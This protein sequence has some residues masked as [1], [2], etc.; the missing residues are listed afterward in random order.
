MRSQKGIREGGLSRISNEGEMGFIGHRFAGW[1]PPRTALYEECCLPRSSPL[2]P[3]ASSPRLSLCIS[4]PRHTV[5]SLSAVSSLIL[6]PQPLPHTRTT[7]LGCSRAW[8]L[9]S[10]LPVWFHSAVAQ[11]PPQPGCPSV[12]WEPSSRAS[13]ALAWSLQ[14]PLTGLWRFLRSLAFL[15]PPAKGHRASRTLYL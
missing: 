1:S 11:K 9:E 13:S 4:P 14:E 15:C 12:T 8:G 2:G 7:V 6:P 3:L 10:E 5:S